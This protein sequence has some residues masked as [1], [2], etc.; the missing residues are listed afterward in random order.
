MSTDTL[1]LYDTTGNWGWLGELYGIMAANLA[2]HFGSWTAQPVVSYSASQIS[3]FSAVIYVGSTYGE[4]LPSA[5]LSDVLA[6][7]TIPVIWVYDNIWQ[8][9]AFTP[10]FAATY[11]WEWSGFDTSNVAQVNYKGQQLSRYT[12]NSA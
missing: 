6:Y 10:N 11:G 2:S 9:V 1:V 7:K 3:Q 4:P 5:F 12:S 8:L